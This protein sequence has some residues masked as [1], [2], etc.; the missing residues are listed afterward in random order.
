MLNISSKP[1]YI[2]KDEFED[3][4]S[5]GRVQ[6]APIHLTV[7]R[8][9]LLSLAIFV[10]A[11][12]LPWTQNIQ[13]NGNITTLFPEHRPQTIHSTIA[14]R[15]ERWYVR[16]G[17]FVKKGDT[18]VQLSEVKA[19]YF[20][21]MLVPRVDA[22]A[23]AKESAVGAY[24]GKAEALAEQQ[25]AMR[26]E[27]D[28][29]IDQ[30]RNKITQARLKIESD[31]IK[32]VQA[33]IDLQIAKRQFEGV[34]NLYEKGLKSLTQ[35]EER[36]MKLQEADA[37][38]V[39]AQNQYESARNDLAIAQTEL[40]LTRNEFAGKL[41]KT[42]SERQ[43]AFSDQYDALAAANKL[44]IER[45]N[46]AYRSQFY[47][48]LAPQD[49]YIVQAITP[50]I[51]EIVK[52]GDPVVSIQPYPFELAVEMY[53]R[54]MDV[55][56]LSVNDQVRFIFDGWPAFFFSG[57]PGLSMGTF[58][59]RVVS[60]DRHISENGLYRVLIK[61]DPEAEYWPDA[62]QVGGGA[63]GIALLNRVPLW[64]EFW[65]VLN[66]FPPDLY[67]KEQ[68]KNEKKKDPIPK[69]PIKKVK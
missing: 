26:L 55:P 25:I 21:P 27:L 30:I 23:K 53:V 28:R 1:I 20:D 19:E 8:L 52:E 42:E 45:D 38:L 3:L 44:R 58:A 65:R 9:L 5:P 39:A 17:R 47:Y 36:R 62:L 54:P 51:G 15:V 18:I 68:E 32:V 61:P 6:V 34:K 14:G 59:G 41:A 49:G 33:E 69:A 13:A 66:G 12:F 57:W 50:G 60:I 29:K 43:S 24:A 40:T 56:L 2:T 31:S 22:Q 7:R 4:K 11:M 37:K 63:R 46:Y 35:F 10:G 48:I 16:E 64:Y 67:S